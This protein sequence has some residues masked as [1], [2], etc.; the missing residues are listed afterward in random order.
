[1]NSRSYSAAV[2]LL[3]IAV[4]ACGSPSVHAF[5]M[6]GQV[7]SIRQ[8]EGFTSGVYLGHIVMASSSMN[9]LIAGGAFEARC[10]SSHTGTINDRR[11]LSASALIGGTELYVTVPEWLPA[12]RQMPGFENVPRGTT[13]MCSYNWTAHAEEATYTVGVPGFNMTI[14]GERGSDGR[15]V[16][17]EMYKPGGS[18]E[19][20]GCIR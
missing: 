16:P 7:Q 15:S 6:R 10:P 4:L 1:M 12:L 11:T 19:D 13:L 14:G 20:N 17:F 9:R 3:A 5:S 2:G 8:Q 18:E